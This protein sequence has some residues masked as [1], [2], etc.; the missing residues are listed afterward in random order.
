MQYQKDGQTF[1]AF[2]VRQ[3]HPNISFAPATYAELG[4]AEYTPPAPTETPAQAQDRLTAAVQR[5]LDATA[6]GHRYDGILSACSYDGDPD[7]VFAAEAAA[8]KAWRS[9]V[10]RYGVGVLAAVEAGT[11]TVPTEAELMAELPAFA[12]P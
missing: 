7:P 9:A 12:M 6:R 4:Y 2:E 11:R 10:W 1:T 5:H 8:F 3:R